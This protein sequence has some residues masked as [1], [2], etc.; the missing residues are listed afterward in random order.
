M[1]GTVRRKPHRDPD[2]VSIA[3]LGPGVP[4]METAKARAEK[5]H[6]TLTA[7]TG[8]LTILSWLRG[9]DGSFNVDEQ[10]L[11]VLD[12]GAQPDV[13]IGHVVGPPPRPPLGAGV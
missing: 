11:G 1:C 8:T 10:V 9:V 2:E 6:A 13:S 3:L 5:S 12:P 4:A 7:A